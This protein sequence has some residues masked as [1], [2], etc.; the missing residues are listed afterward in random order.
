MSD[1]P[2]G[3]DPYNNPYNGCNDCGQYLCI[4]KKRAIVK[5]EAECPPDRIRYCLP[6]CMTWSISFDFVETS[7]IS[8]S[9]FTAPGLFNIKGGCLQSVST[10][11]F[12][13]DRAPTAED[14]DQS[15]ITLPIPGCAGSITGEVYLFG[16]RAEYTASLKPYLLK[17]GKTVTLLTNFIKGENADSQT[18]IQLVMVA[19]LFYCAI[20]DKKKR[21]VKCKTHHRGC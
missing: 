14:L 11:F 10:V 3:H 4:C 9:S 7:S 6:L 16:D 15:T 18:S 20:A 8:P 1:Y 5:I 21:K 2:Y 12:A 13:P 17:S 19:R